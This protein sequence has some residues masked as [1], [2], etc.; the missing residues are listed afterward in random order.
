M[1]GNRLESGDASEGAT[2]FDS[3]ALCQ[4]LAGVVAARSLEKR[5]VVVRFNGSGPIF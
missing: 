2:E 4:S 5:Q 3:P 1:V